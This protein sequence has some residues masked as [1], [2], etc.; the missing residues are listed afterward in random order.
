M[1]DHYWLV[2]GCGC[3]ESSLSGNEL[4]PKELSTSDALRTLPR[5]FFCVQSADFYGLPVTVNAR[6]E[7]D[8]QF[9]ELFIEVEPMGRSR[10]FATVDEAIAAHEEEFFSMGREIAEQ[11]K[12]GLD[13]HHNYSTQDTEMN[14]VKVGIGETGPLPVSWR[15][16]SCI[17]CAR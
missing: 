5:I 12:I 10:W 13:R 11:E 2:G 15:G 8:R 14:S 7:F 16:C 4:T 3:I 1:R 6:V 9:V 17:V